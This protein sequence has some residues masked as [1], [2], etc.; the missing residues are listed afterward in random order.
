M[1]EAKSII[2][3]GGSR[4][5][6]LG[7]VKQVLSAYPQATVFATARN[8]D[9]ATEL[10]ALSDSNKGRIQI[11]AVDADDS[12]SVLQAAA[13]IGEKI[14]SLDVVIYN[15]GVLSGFGNLLDVG[16]QPLIENMTTNVYGAY[17]VAVAFVPL[18]LKSKYERKSLVFL[19]SS[20]ASMQLADEITAVH[21]EAFG[22]G[23]DATA[24]Y[25]VSKTALNRL[26][27][28]LDTVLARQ[29]LPVLLVHPGLVK[30][31]MNAYG[32]IEVPESATGVVNVIQTYTPGKKNFYSWNGD[33]LPW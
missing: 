13:K 9:K 2:V 6:G 21:E 33:A 20:F 31:D 1:S 12:N 8:P 23:F 22:K 26:G 28:E 5:I 29:G 24:L 18:L 32:N 3:I 15:S 19:S 14:G 11:V 7:I 10:Q 4:G 27:K 30:T 17:H 16:A 25:N